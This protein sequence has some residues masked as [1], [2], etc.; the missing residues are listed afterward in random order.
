MMLISNAQTRL[1]VRL[2]YGRPGAPSALCAPTIFSSDSMAMSND[3]GALEPGPSELVP[4]LVGKRVVIVEDEGITVLQ[5]RKLLT[6]AGLLVVGAASNGQD[7]VD[8]VLQERP[9]I[10]LMDITMPV[11]NGLDAAELILS[12]YQVCVVML[13]AYGTDEYRERAR[14]IGACGYITKPIHGPRLLPELDA[15]YRSTAWKHP[16]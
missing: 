9:D 5:L 4:A 1:R 13:T 6:R 7:G 14:Q 12:H 3:S 2:P 15:A 10:V 16:H 11:M 8:V